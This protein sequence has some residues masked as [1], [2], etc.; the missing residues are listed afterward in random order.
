MA[1]SAFS[2][3]GS[4]PGWIYLANWSSLSTRSK[5]Y[6]MSIALEKILF[7]RA[8]RSARF[9]ALFPKH[10]PTLGSNLDRLHVAGHA[11]LLS[12]LWEN[13]IGNHLNRSSV[14]L[15]DEVLRDENRRRFCNGPMDRYF[16]VF[17]IT[18]PLKNV[19]DLSRRELIE[20]ITGTSQNAEAQKKTTEK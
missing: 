18:R 19:F 7:E 12:L 5:L 9:G 15:Q 1:L 6:W 17:V 8:T 11:Q 14:V 4:V 10:N 16:L 13:P 20:L 2:M 3:S